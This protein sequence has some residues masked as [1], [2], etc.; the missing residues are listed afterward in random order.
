MLEEKTSF[1]EKVSQ[2]VQKAKGY[3]KILLSL[4]ALFSVGI[5]F[6][7]GRAS[8]SQ[9]PEGPFQ[10]EAQFSLERDG[11]RPPFKSG[12]RSQIHPVPG[13]EE[14]DATSGASERSETQDSS[15]Q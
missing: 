2:V 3:P 10:E 12:H 5:G 8:S 14:T 7:A 11:Q 6:L 4:L 1:R 9:G 15:R 13:Q